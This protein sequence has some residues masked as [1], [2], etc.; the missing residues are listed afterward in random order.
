M[1]V[2]GYK[3]GTHLSQSHIVRRG[4]V[5]GSTGIYSGDH[6]RKSEGGGA[7]NMNFIDKQ[8][9]HIRFGGLSYQI[10]TII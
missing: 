1:I 10:G 7:L 8:C 3:C 9:T 2:N 4:E 6:R 5:K